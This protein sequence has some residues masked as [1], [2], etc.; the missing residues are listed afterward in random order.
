MKLLI[1]LVVFAAFV[2]SSM[3]LK[4]AICGLPSSY[5]PGPCLALLPTWSYNSARNECVQFTYGGCGGNANNFGT[6]KSCVETCV[7]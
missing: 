3:A 6:L 5:N 7:E 4:H 1:I 2:A